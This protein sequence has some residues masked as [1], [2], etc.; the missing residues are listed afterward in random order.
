MDFTYN[1][2]LIT[3]PIHKYVMHKLA[4]LALLLSCAAQAHVTLETPSA[5]SGSY[6][7]A[8]LKVGHGCDGS[9]TTGISVELPEGAQL[10]RPM[11]K[12]GWQVQVT[13][14]AVKPFDNYGTQVKEDVSRI[15][16]SGGSLPADFYDEFTFQTRIA[17]KPGKLFFKVTQQCAQGSTRWVE[18]PADGQ[19]AHSLKSP[20]AVLQVTEPGEAHH[21]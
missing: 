18:I 15:S 12:A 17:A 8:V 9:P 10:A 21:H 4:I 16:W 13:K 1:T 20:A 5:P 3:I 7:K 14:S 11:P 2:V 19:D 6:Y